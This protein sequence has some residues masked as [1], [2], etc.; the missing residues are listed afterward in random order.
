MN[1]FEDTKQSNH[2]PKYDSQ[3]E[4]DELLDKCSPT[5]KRPRRPQP[6]VTTPALRGLG[7]TGP[8]HII[9]PCLTEKLYGWRGHLEGE[10][11]HPVFW[12]VQLHQKI[13]DLMQSI[14]FYPS[15]SSDGEYRLV[16]VKMPNDGIPVDSWTESANRVVEAS[17]GRLGRIVTDTQHRVYRFEQVNIEQHVQPHFPDTLELVQTFLLD[18]VIDSLEH[19]FIQCLLG[20]ESYGYYEE[21]EDEEFLDPD[22]YDEEVDHVL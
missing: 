13:A 9:Y 21:D 12:G 17:I 20:S 22:S 6:G 8:D 19:P 18:H 16:A 15:L 2:H 10:I 1:N 3:L 4:I 5:S 11:F 7:I 14:A